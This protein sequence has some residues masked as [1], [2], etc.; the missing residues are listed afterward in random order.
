MTPERTRRAARR[1]HAAL[2]LHLA[3]R[4]WPMLLAVVAFAVVMAGDPVARV[5][6][7]VANSER[8]SW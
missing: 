2:C 8:A 3:A 1:E 4:N 7:T 6:E 5:A